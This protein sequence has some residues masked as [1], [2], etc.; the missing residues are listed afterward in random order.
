MQLITKVSAHVVILNKEFNMCYCDPNLR[1][2]CCGGVDCHP[3][4]VKPIGIE[5]SLE[6]SLDPF[7]QDILEEARQHIIE[8]AHQFEEEDWYIPIENS[9]LQLWMSYTDKKQECEMLRDIIDKIPQLIQDSTQEVESYDCW[10]FEWIEDKVNAE[11]LAEK[12]Q[13]LLEDV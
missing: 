12:L 9:Q 10:G 13:A 6:V 2:P 5:D 3:P 4:A 7:K 11:L 1:T 8:T